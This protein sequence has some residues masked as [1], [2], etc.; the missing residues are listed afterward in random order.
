MYCTIWRRILI[1][2]FYRKIALK[3]ALSGFFITQD[4]SLSLICNLGK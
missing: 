3:P 4:F 2:P 1:A